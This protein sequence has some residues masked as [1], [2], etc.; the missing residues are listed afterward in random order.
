MSTTNQTF[1]GSSA[2]QAKVSL[3]TAG[4]VLAAILYPFTLVAFHQ[5][6]GSNGTISGP[7][8][9]ALCLA[10]AFAVPAICLWCALRTASRPAMTASEQRGLRLCYL[11]VAAPTAYTFMGVLWYMLGSPVAD[12][13][14]WVAGL[15][16][17]SNFGPVVLTDFGPP[18]RSL[19]L[20][21][22]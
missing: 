1:L 17:L 14:V 12:E 16:L 18:P 8:L 11:G 7:I 3:M 19:N 10:A 9:A 20:R 5:A 6:I 4:V 22:P 13:W 15:A 2:R 21:C